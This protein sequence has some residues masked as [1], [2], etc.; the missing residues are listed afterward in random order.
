[1]RIRKPRHG[2]EWFI[3]RDFIK[4]LEIRDWLVERVIGNQFQTGLPDL[5]CFKREFGER[6]ID[7]KNPGR[8]SFTAAQ[9]Y[10][11]PLWGK[12]GV[13]IWIITAA[14]QSEY[15]KLFAPPNWRAYWKPQWDKPDMDKLLGEIE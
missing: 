7:I 14:S 11:W 12:F 10:K 15:D 6:W 5:Y 1:M 2:P 3:Q 13:G 4:F 9:K 8:Y